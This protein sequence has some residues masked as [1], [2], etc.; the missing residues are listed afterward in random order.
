MMRSHIV[1]VARGYLG[2][3][4]RHQGRSRQTGVDC[5]GLGVCIARDLGVDVNLDEIPADYKRLP[6]GKTLIAGLDKYLGR[7]QTW[8]EGDILLLALN[9]DWC[10]HLV[11]VTP[12]LCR[13][14]G[15]VHAYI[16]EKRVVEHDLSESWLRGS[17]R[18]AF[19]FPGVES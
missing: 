17:V 19:S 1:D 4:Y 9:S 2:V 8:R 13:P 18:A 6:D 11:I 16:M 7:V 5:L 10:N 15:I 3:K 12:G 14:F